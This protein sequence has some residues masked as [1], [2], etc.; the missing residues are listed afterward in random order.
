VIKLI[1]LDVD[2]CLT[3]G[4]ITYTSDGEEM[5]SF[6]VKDGLGIDSW[7]RMGKKV[8]IITGR[9]SPITERRARELKIEFIYQGVKDKGLVV[10]EIMAKEGL[11]A[12]EIAAIGDDFNDLKMF[13][14][15]GLTFT[16]A[17]GAREIKNRVDVVLS[18]RGGE[19][20]VREM[21]ET[22]IKRDRQEEALF[23]LW[24]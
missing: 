19:G 20:A 23:A 13:S 1:C 22:I 7:V 21:I 15:V 5:K 3:E 9:N 18:A 12:E 8:A 17:D 24:E 2:G 16:P 14:K 4:K 10:E 6:S 11:S